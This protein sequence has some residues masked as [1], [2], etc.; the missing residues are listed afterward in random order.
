SLR[1][2]VTV[3]SL[4][5][6]SIATLCLFPPAT[7]LSLSKVFQDTLNKLNVNLGDV[8]FEMLFEPIPKCPQIF[9]IVVKSLA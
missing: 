1:I 8:Y 6:F 2:L 5:P 9:L 3:L 4:T 7:Q